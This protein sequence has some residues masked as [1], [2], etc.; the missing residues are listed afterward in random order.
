MALRP[1]IVDAL[2]ILRRDCRGDQALAPGVLI[3]NVVQR[4]AK[5][6][7]ILIIARKSR[8]MGGRGRREVRLILA[9]SGFAAGALQISGNAAG[10]RE[11]QRHETRRH[12]RASA[13]MFRK[14]DPPL[15]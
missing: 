7:G 3:D 11:T 12:E 13:P 4:N 8:G 1:H 5:V 2:N 15:P 14:H 9:G 10:G 6:R